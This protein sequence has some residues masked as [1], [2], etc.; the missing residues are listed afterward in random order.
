MKS[1]TPKSETPR[2]FFISI[3]WRENLQENRFSLAAVLIPIHSFL[4]VSKRSAAA[5]AVPTRGTGGKAH[6]GVVVGRIVGQRLPCIPG[7]WPHPGGGGRWGGQTPRGG[8]G[9]ILSGRCQLIPAPPPPSKKR[10]GS[11]LPGAMLLAG[12]KATGHS[13][14]G[15]GAEE[16]STS[17]E[18]LGKKTQYP[19]CVKLLEESSSDTEIPA[20]NE[21]RGMRGVH[22][23]LPFSHGW[24]T[25]RLW[26]RAVSPNVVRVRP[27]CVV[28]GEGGGGLGDGLAKEGKAYPAN[29]IL[30]AT[31]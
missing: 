16:S 25:L 2:H 13:P 7:P 14:R 15:G 4:L 10:G 28:G 24:G 6:R 5:A 11:S 26:D 8:V 18:V 19:R 23:L 30:T 9:S 17:S 20:R 12:S 21:G 1:E 29:R 31:P 22:S 27:W 3:S